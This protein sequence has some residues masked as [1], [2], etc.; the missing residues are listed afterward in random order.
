MTGLLRLEELSVGYGARTIVAGID[1]AVGTGESLLVIGHNGAGKTTLLR[2][3]FG[4]QPSLGGNVRLFGR[5]VHPGTTPELMVS[6]ARY[7][8]QGL[9][10]FG[11]LR[12]REHRA[13]L[14]RLYG[15]SEGNPF[16]ERQGS[17]KRVRDLSVG[18]RRIEALRLLDA[19]SPRL[20]F[21]D[22]PTA[23]V[24][25]THG[26][27]VLSWIAAMQQRGAAFVVVEHNFER[28][29]DICRT[30]MVI[31]SGK[32]TYCGP[33]QALRDPAVLANHFL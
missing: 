27:K 17:S 9:R 23:G 33:S 19:G 21:L 3:L 7:L 4:L 8:A 30:T 31:R 29:F 26:T 5:D 32:V 25:L 22:E 2:T 10:Y 12:V 16:S 11:E 24:D 1:A 15:F 14:K 13:V 18:Q 6:G 28:M 20:F